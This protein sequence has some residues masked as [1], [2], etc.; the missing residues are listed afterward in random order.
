MGNLARK[1]K[2]LWRWVL[3]LAS[4]VLIGGLAT[5]VL[6]EDIDWPGT[7][8]ENLSE[9]PLDRAWQP[10]M[11]A[12]DTGKIVVA[13]SDERSTGA[14]DIYAVESN[15][16]GRSWSYPQPVA[17]SP[18]ELLLPGTVVVGDRCF[19]SWSTVLPS[20][21]TYVYETE[22]G[23]GTVRQIPGS[24]GSDWPPWPRLTEYDG[25][26]HAVFHGGGPAPN[27]LYASRYLTASQWMTATV[28]Y[29]HTK[30]IGSFYPA[31]AVG[32]D[33]DTLHVV[34]EERAHSWERSIFYMEGDATGP[35]VSWS[36]AVTLSTGITLSVWPSVVVDSAGE[37]YVVWGEQVGTGDVKDRDHYVRFSHRNVMSAV[38]DWS[39]PERIDSEP[40][41]VNYLIPTAVTLSIA[42]LENDGQTQLCVAWHGFREGDVDTDEEV[43]VSCSS[44]QG[45]TW[46]V[47][48]NMSRT[49]GSEETSIVPVIV[50][51]SYGELQGVW[52]ERVGPEAV[53]DREIYHTRRLDKSIYLPLVLKGS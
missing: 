39:A 25:R 31:V 13:W 34:W 7:I 5:V 28:A 47:P 19:I 46:S 30:A 35:T 3:L 29:T 50:F 8:P 51:D 4:L 45:A 12:S 32:P 27:V 37:V 9:S 21:E 1:R 20:R 6:A 10:S 15:D 24:L 22:L 33:E 18:D 53:E 44:D 48:R 52:E 14:R 2:E 38:D 42:L 16:S 41:R 49:S 17:T 23:S 11:A 43:L 26:L 40:V 36:P